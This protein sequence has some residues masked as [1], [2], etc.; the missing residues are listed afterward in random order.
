M[1]TFTAILLW[2][3]MLWRR[4]RVSMCVYVENMLTPRARRE[5]GTR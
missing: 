4:S 2:G 3:A 5:H 1:N